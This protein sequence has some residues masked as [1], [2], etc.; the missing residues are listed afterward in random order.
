MNALREGMTV[1]QYVLVAPLGGEA[2][3]QAWLARHPDAAPDSPP[4]VVTTVPVATVPDRARMKAAL[5]EARVARTLCHPGLVPLEELAETRDAYYSVTQYVTGR[6]LRQILNRAGALRQVPPVWFSLHVVS[7]V[8]DA[9]AYLHQACAGL[10]TPLADLRRGV[11]PQ[12]IVVSFTGQARWSALG[13]PRQQQVLTRTNTLGLGSWYSYAAPERLAAP[14]LPLDLDRA[15]VYSLGVVLYEL[16][17]GRRPFQATHDDGLLHEVLSARTDPARP[18]EHAPWVTQDLEDLVLKSIAW[19]VGARFPSAEALGRALRVYLLRVGVQLTD[20]HVA[21]QVC[22]V[23]SAP[24]DAAPP[25]SA[26]VRPD[27]GF[28]WHPARKPDLGESP[29]EDASEALPHEPGPDDG[30][31]DP[32][33]RAAAAWE[34]ALAARDPQDRGE[35]SDGADEDE[36]QGPQGRDHLFPYGARHDWDGAVK[37]V[38]SGLYASVLPAPQRALECFD[39]GMDLVRRRDYVAAR[40]RLERA[41]ELDPENRVYAVNLRRLRDAIRRDGS[42]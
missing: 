34:R 2:P 11:T 30:A 28:T 40:E 21:Q 1:G 27:S 9:L 13:L 6:S 7:T 12:A 18:S 15:E 25:P 17:T 38:Q 20:K 3:E 10:G 41:V 37:K 24:A 29:P 19:D 16:L 26:R 33:A 8:C 39:Q 14:D 36:T 35:G 42:G 23:K 31:A 22:G 32:R 5:M 4:L